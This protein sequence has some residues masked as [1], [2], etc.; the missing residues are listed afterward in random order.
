MFVSL[1]PAPYALSMLLLIS[2]GKNNVDSHVFRIMCRC[3]C[4]RDCW[5]EDF[6]VNFGGCCYFVS[7]LK[8]AADP[9]RFLIGRNSI[10]L[11]V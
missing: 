6:V 3:S 2:T 11:H 4:F 10:E 8:F 9:F 5:L 7:S 1:A